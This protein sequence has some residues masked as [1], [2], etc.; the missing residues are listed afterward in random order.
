MI[1]VPFSLANNE[2]DNT[3][4]TG[5]VPRDWIKREHL[6]LLI[7]LLDDRSLT[8]PVFSAAADLS[9]TDKPYTTVGIEALRLIQGYMDGI[10]PSLWPEYYAKDTV[11]VQFK[12]E[13]HV[14]IDW[15]NK[16]K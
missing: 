14:V 10:Y 4:G 13:K 2:S 3:I 9:A 6:E 1:L 11:S 7:Q 5:V 8:F 12:N 16:N 15:W